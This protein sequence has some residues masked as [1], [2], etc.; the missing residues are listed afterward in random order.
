MKASKQGQEEHKEIFEHRKERKVKVDLTDKDKQLFK[1]LVFY[2]EILHEGK[3]IGEYFKNKV[4]EFGGRLVEKLSKNVTH[5]VWGDGKPK[6]LIKAQ[7]MGIKIITPLWL[8]HCISE[9]ELTDEAKFSPAHMRDMQHK[10]NAKAMKTLKDQLTLTEDQKKRSLYSAN[11][12]KL[13]EARGEPSEKSSMVN[14]GT[15]S[16]SRFENSQK[17]PDSEPPAFDVKKALK[18]MKD[19]DFFEKEYAKELKKR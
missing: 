7:D 10:Q 12:A 11:Q 19:D 8:E 9:L 6:T 18:R 15:E 1:N 13:S 3:P 5:V 4:L 2:F 17:V 16:K 14:R